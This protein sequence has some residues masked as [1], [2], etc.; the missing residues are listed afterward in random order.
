[1]C[2]PLG[3]TWQV[4]PLNVHE[5]KLRRPLIVSALACRWV[6]AKHLC[7]F[8]P[9]LLWCACECQTR[10]SQTEGTFDLV[11]TFPSSDRVWG[12]AY[13][14]LVFTISRAF[15]PMCTSSSVFILI[16]STVSLVCKMGLDEN[17]AYLWVTRRHTKLHHKKRSWKMQLPS[18]QLT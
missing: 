6:T 13:K 12:S 7:C 3:S 10:N 4:T 2:C 14:N 5:H 9:Q 17:K 18:S 16:T 11:G 8:L 15:C 1:M